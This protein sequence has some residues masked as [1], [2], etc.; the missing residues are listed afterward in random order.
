[1]LVNR[2][3]KKNKAAP[4]IIVPSTLVAANP[5]ARSISEVRIE[6]STPPSTRESERHTQGLGWF[7][8]TKKPIRS[9]ARNT[10]ATTNTV[11][12]KIGTISITPVK[13]STAPII[14][15]I[16]L[17]TNASP[18]QLYLQSQLQ[19]IFTPPTTLY[20]FCNSR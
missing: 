16:R 5:A 6:P 12:K 1:M 11:E 17:A 19:N 2:R 10:A 7:L 18:L 8:F 3:E 14:P 13:L 15:I 9:T 20:D 4:R